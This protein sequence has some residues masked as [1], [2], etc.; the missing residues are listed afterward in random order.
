M[1]VWRASIRRSV[2]RYGPLC[3]RISLHRE[4]DTDV[5]PSRQYSNMAACHIKL[6]NWKKALEFALNALKINEDDN[7]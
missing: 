4:S 3:S 1:I 5:M 2:R 6:Q 7:K